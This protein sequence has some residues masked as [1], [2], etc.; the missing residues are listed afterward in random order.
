[1]KA[2]FKDEQYYSQAEVEQVNKLDEIF[3]K[4]AG[5]LV[6]KILNFPK[7]V[8][9]TALS[10]FLVKY[11]IFKKVMEIQ[12]SVVECGVLFGGGL[13]TWAQI[14][15]ILEPANHQRRVIGFDTFEGFP[16][17]TKE[18]ESRQSSALLKK[19]EM[20]VD[21]YSDLQECVK[22]FDKTRFFSNIPKVELVK[23]DILETVPKYIV[24]N[25]HLVISL[26]YL[27]VDIFAPT[28]AALNN[29]IPRMPKGAIVAFDEFAHPQFPGETIAVF[30]KFNLNSISMRKIPVLGT[31]IC[32][33]TVGE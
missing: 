7:Y 20:A 1:M 22:I 10:R 4:G 13:M 12:G 31:S 3:Q 18:D 17:I 21:S 2:S 23:G 32:Y 30:K 11:E 33:F 28:V 27:D 15:S 16:G 29:F 8:S 9:R 19:G 26:L 25:P 24:D 6:D 5:T 14:S